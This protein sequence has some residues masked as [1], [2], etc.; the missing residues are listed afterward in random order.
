MSLEDRLAVEDVIKRYCRAVDEADR[1]GLEAVFAEDAIFR[2]G[3]AEM[4]IG[5]YIDTVMAIKAHVLVTQHVLSNCE[6][7]IH[8]T[9]AHADS[10]YTAYHDVP[11]GTDAPPPFGGL[12]DRMDALVAGSYR[13]VLTKGEGGWRIQDR[14]TAIMWQRW[15]PP[16]PHPGGWG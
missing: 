4:P 2:F 11:P 15:T 13:D 10:Y 9:R 1:P 7:T 8:G 12:A 14:T 5:S 3:D 16:A 6:V